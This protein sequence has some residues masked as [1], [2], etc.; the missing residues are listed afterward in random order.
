V[1]SEDIV[2]LVRE[3]VSELAD[4]TFPHSNPWAVIAK[5][6]YRQN[7]E[8][9]VWWWRQNKDSDIST[10]RTLR[11]KVVEIRLRT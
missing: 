2:P 8:W 4:F 1:N 6:L 11:A 5:H 10:W 9:V 7:N 3:A